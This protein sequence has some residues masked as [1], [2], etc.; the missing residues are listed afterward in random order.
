MN[1]TKKLFSIIL[2][3][4][5]CFSVTLINVSAATPKITIS[6]HESMPDNEVTVTISISN[7]PGIMAMAFCIT[8][9]SDSLVYK[10]YSKGYLTNYTIKDHPDKGHVSFVNVENKDNSSNGTIISVLLLSQVI[11]SSVLISVFFKYSDTEFDIKS[12]ISI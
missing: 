9:D 2:C 3:L 4:V 10:N 6:S 7:N 11:I 1:F 12:F 5:I 8:Y